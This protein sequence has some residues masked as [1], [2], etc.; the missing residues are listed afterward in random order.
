[1]NNKTFIAALG[2]S[3][4][5]A[6][7]SAQTVSEA[8][9]STLVNFTAPASENGGVTFKSCLKCEAMTLRVTAATRYEING[10]QVRLDQFRKVVASVRNRDRVGLTVLHHL[11]SGRVKLISIDIPE[12]IR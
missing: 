10:E 7:A 12:R 8:Y 4:L 11:E 3:I 1:M 5:F 6:S 9:E 2:L